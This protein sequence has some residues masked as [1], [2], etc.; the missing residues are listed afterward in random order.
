MSE[1]TKD[2]LLDTAERL[3]GQQGYEAT[4]LRHIIAEAGVNLAAIHYHFGSKQ[5]LLDEIV[6]RQAGPVN[7]ERLA[8]LNR[9]EAEAA[10]EPL[11]V[12]KILEAFMRPM[13]HA[14]Q[15]RPEFVRVM[16]R[17]Y[18]EGLMDTV[19]Q[20]NFQLVVTRFVPALRRSLSHLPEEEF[21]DR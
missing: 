18:A 16:G 5:E 9:A 21:L 1:T 20:R 17:I 3:F 12:V 4:S 13:A 8:L 14:A 11:P 6:A 10:G 2:K 19:I 7:D 15:R